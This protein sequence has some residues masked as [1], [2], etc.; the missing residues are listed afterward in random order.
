MMSPREPA[1][2]RLTAA[3]RVYRA[4]SPGAFA[5][6][7]LLA[8]AAGAP[9][10]ELRCRTGA[11]PKASGPL[12]WFH[13]ASAGEMA[14]ALRLTMLLRQHG[15]RFTAA[16]TAANRAGVE[17][18]ARAA[19]PESITA[20]GPWDHPR[21]VARALD[22]WRP[23]AIFLV[24]TEL[25]P[26]LIFEA[27]RRHVPIVC[28]SARI[29]ARD[30]PRYRLVRGLTATMLRRLTGILSQNEIERERLLALGAPAD[31]CV[32]AGNLK[33]LRTDTATRG[34]HSLREAL[35]LRPDDQVIVCGS[36]HRDEVQLLFAALSRQMFPER[37]AIIAPRHP[38][39]VATIVREAQR[40]DWTCHLHTG[41]PPPPSWQ[42]LVLGAMGELA[43]AYAMASLAVVGGGFGKHGGHNP[44]EPVMLGVPVI[45]GRH[46]ENFEQETRALTAVLPEAQVADASELATRVHEW[47]GSETRRRQVAALQQQAL[48]NA[49]DIATRYIAALSCWLP[50]T[51]A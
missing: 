13:G 24:E 7:W 41:A 28:V 3:E 37:R 33:Y 4:V 36:V 29:Y 25:W 34:T 2:L 23:Q 19:T 43:D 32:A 1:G 8:R 39:A 35:G 6:V 20:F 26:G 46:S 9:R 18:A 11:M 22:Q 44:F 10:S 45:F 17:L 16:Y 5:L 15:Q 30:F 12:L 47:L 40:R 31:R 49:T 14:A 38:S 48:P 50:G 42:V 21:W 27:Y 51:W